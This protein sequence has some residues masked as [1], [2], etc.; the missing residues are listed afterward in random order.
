MIKLRTDYVINNSKKSTH[1]NWSS[2]PLELSIVSRKM[3]VWQKEMELVENDRDYTV[4][5]DYDTHSFN[6]GC[7]Y[8][9]LNNYVT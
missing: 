3:W 2:T 4:D 8:S 6:D 7:S 9:K 5:G 1:N